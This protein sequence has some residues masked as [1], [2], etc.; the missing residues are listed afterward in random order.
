MGKQ[1]KSYPE[2]GGGHAVHAHVQLRV[3]CRGVHP[4]LRVHDRRGGGE[5]R[6]QA[7]RAGLII[8]IIITAGGGVYIRL[9]L[10]LL[11]PTQ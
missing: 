4:V 6:H 11:L 2:R 8:I 3:C 9:L 1:W 10:L 5:G 7:T